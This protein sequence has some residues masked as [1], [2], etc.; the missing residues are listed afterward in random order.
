M[1]VSS[2]QNHYL[3]T[4]FSPKNQYIIHIIPAIEGGGLNSNPQ[5]YLA[6]DI[7]LIHITKE[8]NFNF[9]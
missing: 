8:K 6:F 3:L 4:K 9:S 5:L 7:H 1:L 2:T